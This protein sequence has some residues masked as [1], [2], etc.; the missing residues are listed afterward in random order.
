M[1]VEVSL[2][3]GV[4][5][6]AGIVCKSV[7]GLAKKMTVIV[8]VFRNSTHRVREANGDNG[9]AHTQPGAP[10]LTACCRSRVAEVYEDDAVSVPGLS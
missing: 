3:H 1:T 4:A 6:D 7:E 10:D 2:E 8:N 9:S 5:D